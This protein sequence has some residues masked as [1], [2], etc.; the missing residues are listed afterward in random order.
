M[1]EK[2]AIFL[3]KWSL[4]QALMYTGALGVNGLS[5]LFT[6]LVLQLKLLI[7]LSL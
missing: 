2:V 3:K 6:T 7:F 4:V 5:F 1:I